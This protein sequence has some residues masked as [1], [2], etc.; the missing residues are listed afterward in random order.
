MNVHEDSREEVMKKSPDPIIS[1]RKINQIEKYA[2]ILLLI[3]FVTHNNSNWEK[4]GFLR[5][6]DL[7][8]HLKF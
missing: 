2:K 4:D 6:L 7:F 3:K 8:P 5:F 1:K